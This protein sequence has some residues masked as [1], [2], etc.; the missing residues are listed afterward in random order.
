M[1]LTVHRNKQQLVVSSG[2]LARRT[3][4]VNRLLAIPN[5]LDDAIGEIQ[6]GGPRNAL[7]VALLA[8]G[9]ET[10][11]RDNAQVDVAFRE[12]SE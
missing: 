12:D 9:L 8:L 7:Y 3:Q 5:E 11:K 2:R 6:V 4:A 1:T 10:L